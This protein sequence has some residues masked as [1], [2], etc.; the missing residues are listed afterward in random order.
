MKILKAAI[1][2]RHARHFIGDRG[3]RLIPVDDSIALVDREPLEQ[4]ERV[5]RLTLGM[6]TL[7]VTPR[8]RCCVE[9]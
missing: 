7:V 4:V 3:C 2:P 1:L 6:P 9:V 5:R 8:R